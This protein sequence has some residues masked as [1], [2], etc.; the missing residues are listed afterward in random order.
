MKATMDEPNMIANLLQE[1]TKREEKRGYGGD[2][3]E[4]VPDVLTPPASS[5]TKKLLLSDHTPPPVGVQT[6]TC[7]S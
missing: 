5:A 2:E 6:V 1:E 4:G 7:M 3:G